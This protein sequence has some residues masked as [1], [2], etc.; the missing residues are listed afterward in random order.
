M[1]GKG[2][3]RKGA[4]GREGWRREGGKGRRRKGGKKDGAGVSDIDQRE[5]G[6]GSSFRLRQLSEHKHIVERG[7]GRM[8]DYET[9]I[10]GVALVSGLRRGRAL[11]S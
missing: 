10:K 6:L 3:G 2:K 11:G 7:L 4:V 9:L 5:P 8:S 1:R